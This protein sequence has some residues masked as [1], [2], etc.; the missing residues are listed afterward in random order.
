ML[1][2]DTLVITINMPEIFIDAETGKPLA[3]EPIEF[4]IL[5]GAQYTTEQFKELTSKAES[6]AQISLGVTIIEVIIIF[7]FKKVLFSMWVL[8]LTLQFFVYL[9]QW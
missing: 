8:I 1:E 4:R 6:A 3:Q 5:L 9:S 7:M 2:P